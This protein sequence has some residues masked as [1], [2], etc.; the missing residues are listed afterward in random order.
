[1]L[2]FVRLTVSGLKSN[3]A[4]LPD[5]RELIWLYINSVQ[6]VNA[7]IKNTFSEIFHP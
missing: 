2:D 7:L 3:S 4:E 1:M 6:R 5:L